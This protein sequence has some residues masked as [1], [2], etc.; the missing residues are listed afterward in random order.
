[1]AA[2]RLPLPLD[3][4]EDNY[5]LLCL[6]FEQQVEFVQQNMG[7]MQQFLENMRSLDPHGNMWYYANLDENFER[8]MGFAMDL[9]VGDYDFGGLLY[10]LMELVNENRELFNALYCAQ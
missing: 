9:L 1:M 8:Q 4:S 6:G 3:L 7:L 2:Q 10:N 5:D